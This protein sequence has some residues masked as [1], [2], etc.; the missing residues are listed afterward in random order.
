MAHKKK[1]IT[2]PIMKAWL[3]HGHGCRVSLKIKPFKKMTAAQKRA[4]KGCV[5]KKARLA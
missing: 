3:T 4:L 1:T 5:M 2:N